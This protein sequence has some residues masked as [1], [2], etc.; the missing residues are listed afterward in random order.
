MM[1]DGYVGGLRIGGDAVI[2][3][4]WVYVHRTSEIFFSSL[5]LM[6]YHRFLHIPRTRH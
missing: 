5:I 4:I 3:L 2:I 6:V 1:G